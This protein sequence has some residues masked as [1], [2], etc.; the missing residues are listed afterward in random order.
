MGL[1]CSLKGHKWGHRFNLKDNKGAGCKCNICG[2]IR[3]EG[4]DYERC[5]CKICGHVRDMEHDWQRAKDKDGKCIIICAVCGR[6]IDSSNAEPHTLNGCQCVECGMQLG[7]GHKFEGCQ[8]VICGSP[9]TEGHRDTIVPRAYQATISGPKCGDIKTITYN[10]KT[11]VC[12]QCN[13]KVDKD[14]FYSIVCP[15][16]GEIGF[17]DSVTFSGSDG[18]EMDAFFSCNNCGYTAQFV[19]THDGK[20][21]RGR[22]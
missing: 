16:C 19:Y 18:Y 13:R 3:K 4:H 12:Q 20:D 11:I 6:T 14:Q 2:K 8:C 17:L 10:K 9:R 5:K 1:I 22:V 15:G 21:K 7:T